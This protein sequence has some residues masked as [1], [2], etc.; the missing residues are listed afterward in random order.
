ME[1]ELRS[2]LIAVATAF[3]DAE[4]CGLSTVSRRCRN[5]SGFFHR[6]FD[7]TKSFTLRTFDEVMQ[8]FSDNWPAGA[9]WPVA[10]DRPSAASS[11]SPDETA[12]R[13]GGS[14]L[15]PNLQTV[16]SPRSISVSGP[17]RAV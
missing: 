17:E 5:D 1:S 10:I 12:G 15:G 2:N 4:R 14:S 7:E 6:L 11:P 8:W 13:V 3:A 16:E 9:E